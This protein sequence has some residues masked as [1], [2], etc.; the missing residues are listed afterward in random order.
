[1]IYKNILLAIDGSTI[2]NNAIEEVIKLTQD[3]DVNLRIINVVDE[4]PAYGGPS[5]DTFSLINALK[6][7]GQEILDNAEK[8]IKG[9]TSLNVEKCLIE[10][11][12]LQ[13]R[14]AEI[15]M[16]EAKEWPA[17]LLVIGSHGRRGFSRLLLGSVA[18]NIMRLATIPVLLVHG[19]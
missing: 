19:S 1:M 14:V 13:G 10:R 17:D 4:K 15:I 3:H 11:K 2:S 5:F 12:P 16:E 18:E 8:I 9:R 7:E 6:E